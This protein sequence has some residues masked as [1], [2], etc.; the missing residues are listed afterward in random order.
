MLET[1]KLRSWWEVKKKGLNNLASLA[2]AWALLWPMTWQ[3]QGVMMEET[4]QNQQEIIVEDSAKGLIGTTI[5]FEK[6]KELNDIEKMVESLMWLDV[7]QDLLKI[8]DENYIRGILKEEVTESINKLRWWKYSDEYIDQT[9]VYVVEN[10]DIFN[11]DLDRI[12]QESVDDPEFQEAMKKWDEETMIRIIK[13]K[14]EEIHANNVKMTWLC[15]SPL[16]F[17]VILLVASSIHDRRKQ[18]K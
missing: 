2:L 3:A 11:K 5:K 9:I 6:A 1:T 17:W 8:Y 16:L 10:I 4:Q 15:I 18:K 12:I 13:H 7:V 14:P